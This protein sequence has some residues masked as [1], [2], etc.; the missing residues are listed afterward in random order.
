MGKRSRSD[1]QVNHTKQMLAPH[2]EN[3]YKTLTLA[4]R[5]DIY[6]SELNRECK[7]WTVFKFVKQHSQKKTS[8][9]V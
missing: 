9:L 5:S 3:G 4:K 1:L 7:L 6:C 2:L 8:F